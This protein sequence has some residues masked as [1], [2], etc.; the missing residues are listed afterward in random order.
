MTVM[1][2]VSIQ[3]EDLD[4]GEDLV[5]KQVVELQVS[6]EVGPLGVEGDGPAVGDLAAASGCL[7]STE[8]TAE[9][10]SVGGYHMVQEPGCCGEYS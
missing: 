5:F 9:S 2:P 8:I 3:L 4:R 1:N 7:Y 6:A 10:I